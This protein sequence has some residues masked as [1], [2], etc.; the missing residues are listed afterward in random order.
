L[1]SSR[2]NV[3]KLKI[4]LIYLQLLL[5]PKPLKGLTL[6]AVPFRKFKGQR[7]QK[8]VNLMTLLSRAGSYF[9][10]HLIFYFKGV[11]ELTAIRRFGSLMRKVNKRTFSSRPQGVIKKKSKLVCFSLQTNLAEHAFFSALLQIPVFQRF[12]F[13]NTPIKI[14]KCSR[15]Y[16]CFEQ[17]K[18]MPWV[19]HI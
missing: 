6:R 14:D 5:Y 2:A 8:R 12:K 9:F 18:T 16:I 17:P 19:I 3:I 10:I 15:E 7:G 4:K 13:Q 11:H 1:P